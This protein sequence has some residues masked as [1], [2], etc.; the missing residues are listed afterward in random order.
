MKE[1]SIF[2]HFTK[3]GANDV[4]SWHFNFTYGKVQNPPASQ[5]HC[6][7]I[8]TEYWHWKNP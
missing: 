5:F 1:K 7:D 4:K 3:I 2:L 8:Y 6:K